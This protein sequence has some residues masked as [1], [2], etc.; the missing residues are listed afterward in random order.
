VRF[1]HTHR[2]GPTAHLYDVFSWERP[3][4]RAGRVAAIQQLGLKPGDR[5]FDVGCGT[6]LNFPLLIAAV[7]TSGEVVGIDASKAMLERAQARARRE[8]WRNVTTV[9]GDAATAATLMAGRDSFDAV[10]F[11]Y[12][13]SV[14]GEWRAAWT[15]A[16]AVLRPGGR[17]AVVDSALP[18]GRWRLL[19]P[20]ARLALFAGGV[21]RHRNPWELALT[22]T[23][24]TFH[25]VLK[26]GHVHVAVGTVARPTTAGAEVG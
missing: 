21:D 11:T 6:G 7:G 18:T 2:Y 5:V 22:A 19:S 24:D 1:A 20:V 14:I 10:L 15:Q 12:S 9:H 25:E 17:V 26:G 23:T 16:L 8:G 4:Y 3:V 13:L